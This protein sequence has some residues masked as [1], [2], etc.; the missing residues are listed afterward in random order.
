M[1]M[2]TQYHNV[3]KIVQSEKHQG[4]GCS[5]IRVTRALGCVRRPPGQLQLL[6][7][8]TGDVTAASM[9]SRPDVA[10]PSK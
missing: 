5:V 3:V 2:P 4:H 9:P 8:A 10:S 1:N 7:A 6:T